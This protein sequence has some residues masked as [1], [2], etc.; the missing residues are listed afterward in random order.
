[1]RA[2]GGVESAL[3]LAQGMVKASAVVIARERGRQQ[4]EIVLAVTAETLPERRVNP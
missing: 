3:E 4:A 1:M 2:A